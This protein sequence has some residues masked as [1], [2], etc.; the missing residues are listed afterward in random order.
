M[1]TQ[2]RRRSATRPRQTSKTT[3]VS[4]CTA[5]K[6]YSILRSENSSQ[7]NVEYEPCCCLMQFALRSIM[8]HSMF[9][10]EHVA[11]FD[12]VGRVAANSVMHDHVGHS[13]FGA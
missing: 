7:R 4:E 9:A 11:S 10:V 1:P 3:K 6:T 8:M 2:A 12:M 5:Q 13:A